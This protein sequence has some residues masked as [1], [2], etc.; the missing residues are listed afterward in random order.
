VAAIWAERGS[1][2]D[3]DIVDAFID[4]A[5]QFRAI[6]AQFADDPNAFQEE[7]RRMEF[8][9]VEETIVLGGN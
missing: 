3:P 1:H 6:A 8:T 9:I 2:F 7:L 4:I 5:D